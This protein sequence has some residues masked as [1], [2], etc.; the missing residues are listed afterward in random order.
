MVVFRLVVT[1]LRYQNCIATTYFSWKIKPNKVRYQ[2]ATSTCQPGIDQTVKTVKFN[3][4]RTLVGIKMAAEEMFYDQ[5]ES[6]N[7]WKAV[8][9]R[10]VLSIAMEQHPTM[11]RMRYRWVGIKLLRFLEYTLVVLPHT[12]CLIFSN[13]F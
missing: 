2:P 12:E 10:T 4:L 11:R 1:S 7:Q 8:S 3:D 13:E 5:I 9:T 6:R